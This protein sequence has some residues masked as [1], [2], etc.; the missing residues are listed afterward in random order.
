MP[1]LA[2]RALALSVLAAFGGAAS[3]A[4]PSTVAVPLPPPPP[5]T[6]LT[7]PAAARM[8]LVAAKAGLASPL[9]NG[10]EGGPMLQIEAATPWRTTSSGVALAWALP[11]RTM[12]YGTTQRAGLEFGGTVLELTPTARASFPL[13]LSRVSFRTE[14]GI[15]LVSRWT[16]AQVDT[17]FLGR[18]TETAQT[19]S[20]VVRMGLGI[21]WAVNPR[22]SIALEP[23]S[24]GFDFDGNADWI[25]GGGVA[26]RL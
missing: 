10:G 3:A 25:F 11:L 6:T 5:G 26:Y 21:D 12:L 17:Q 9:G 1:A 7:R 16:W 18:R 19:T 14:A 15:G 24:L 8:V 13:G 20:A 2:R 22:V 4:P 23:L